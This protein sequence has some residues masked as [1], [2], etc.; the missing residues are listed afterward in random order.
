MHT[1]HVV[2]LQYERLVQGSLLR[3]YKR[4]LA[5]VDFDNSSA[6]ETVPVVVHCPNTGPMTGLLDRCQHASIV[7]MTSNN[8]LY[9]LVSMTHECMDTCRQCT[10]MLHISHVFAGR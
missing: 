8:H 9:L 2:Y 5:D 4:F 10:S 1:V 3:R 7:N 6:A